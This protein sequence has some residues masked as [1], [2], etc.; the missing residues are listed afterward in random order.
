MAVDLKV[1]SRHVNEVVSP[2]VI[3]DVVN[4]GRIVRSL[5]CFSSQMAGI[6]FDIFD[7]NAAFGADG[8]S[9]G[10]R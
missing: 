10:G 4:G 6:S 7:Y 5:G 3:R 8:K 1:S 9:L 2:P